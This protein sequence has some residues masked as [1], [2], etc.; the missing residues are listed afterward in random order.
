MSNDDS[1]SAYIDNL[2]IWLGQAY[3]WQVEDV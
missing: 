3:Q 2:K 1:S